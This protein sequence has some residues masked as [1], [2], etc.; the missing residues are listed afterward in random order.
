MRSVIFRPTGKI[1]ADGRPESTPV[2]L[3]DTRGRSMFINGDRENGLDASFRHNAVG[4][5]VQT[6]T[7]YQ[8]VTDT[9]TYIKKQVSRQT[10]Y[11]FPIA[12]LVPVHVGEGAW[13]ANILTNRVMN[14]GTDFESGILRTGAGGSRIPGTEVAIDGI[15]LAVANWAW[16]VEYTTIELNQALYANNWDPIVEKHE[17][18]KK[19][20]D[21]GLQ[22]VSLLGTADGLQQG[23][24]N[25]TSVNVDTTT[26][27]K[28]IKSMNAS[29]LATF[30]GRVIAAYFTN[31]NSTV[32]PDTFVIPMQDFLGLTQMTPGTL[33]AFPVPILKYLE[34]AFKVA[35]RNPNFQ[36]I[37]NAYADKAV[38]NSIRGLN[39]NV[40]MLYRKDAKTL[41]MDIPVD[42]TTSQPGTA[43]NFK[44]ED[45]AYGQFTGMGFYKPLEVLMFTHT[46]AA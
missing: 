12:E 35:T 1:G 38:N 31:T 45:V 41:R 8:I 42:F 10:F 37:G 13:A 34:D 27:A 19:I 43:N 17:A 2:F 28:F 23:L 22:K 36:I 29:E 24:L 33:G 14:T 46:V 21:T 4:D 44:W 25:T 15:T 3:T 30:V 32:L 40:Y 18:R 5:S 20:W 11:E 7:A 16:G 9:L 26:I 6:A 39:K